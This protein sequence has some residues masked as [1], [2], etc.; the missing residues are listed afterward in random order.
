MRCG[1]AP[2][3]IAQQALWPD[4]TIA[5]LGLGSN[6]GDRERHLA[7]ATTEL[8]AHGR[9]VA[10]SS[11]YE[12]AP[13][14]GPEQ[15]PFLNSVVLIETELAPRDLLEACLAIEREHGRVRRERWGP[16]TLDI[17]V[18][19]YGDAVV[20][21]PGLEIP[22]PGLAERRF[23]LEPLL[24]VAPDARLPDGSRVGD[25]ADAVADQEVRRIGTPAVPR[26]A[27]VAVFVATGLAAIILWWALGGIL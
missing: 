14:G 9:V 19:L 10:S 24:E 18:L 20:D 17:D 22:H 5:A 21:E 15:E 1:E 6:V 12:T 26:T 8:E 25:L 16:R 3:R 11:Q 7:D 4:V 13:I 2:Q 27:T 23:V